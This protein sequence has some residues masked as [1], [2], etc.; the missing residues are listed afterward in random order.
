MTHAVQPSIPAPRPR[1]PKRR[2]ARR[3]F[4]LITLLLL[5]ACLIAPAMLGHVIAY[6]LQSEVATRLHG[7]LELENVYYIFPYGVRIKHASLYTDESSSQPVLD[8]GQIVIKL[9]RFPFGTGLLIFEQAEI[10]NPTVRIIKT[11]AGFQ[12]A[13]LPARQSFMAPPEEKRKLSD[14]FELRHLS[15][16]Q[17]QVIYEDR[18]ND[19]TA[20]APLTWK[21]LTLDFRL[22]PTSTSDYQFIFTA[23]DAALAKMSVNGAINIDTLQLDVPGMNVE[24]NTDPAH[25][26]EQLPPQLQT[27]F[28]KYAVG[29]HLAFTAA[30]KIPLKDPDRATISAQLDLHNGA[31]RLRGPGDILSTAEFTLTA[32]NAPAQTPATLATTLPVALA[33]RTSDILFNLTNLHLAGGDQSLKIETAQARIDR[34]AST[35]A[36]GQIRGVADAGP[37][38]G[39]LRLT[40]VQ[41][42]IPFTAAGF[43]A[44]GDSRDFVIRVALDKANGLLFPRR[45]PVTEVAGKLQITHDILKVSE[46]TGTICGGAAAL[47]GQVSWNNFTTKGVS[48][49]ADG[50]LLDAQMS[51]I[52]QVFIRNEKTRE[53]FTGA[54]DLRAAFSGTFPRRPATQ[55]SL[56]SAF[57]PA[58]APLATT[59]LAIS[60]GQLPTATDTLT[61]AGDFDIRRGSFYQ[62]PVLKTVLGKMKEGDAATVGEAAASFTIAHRIIHFNEAAANSP[63]LGIAGDGDID[64]DGDVDMNFVVTPLADWR[65]K[66]QDTGVPVIKDVVALVAGAA[67]VVLNTAQKVVIYQYRVIGRL[68]A[69]KSETVPFPALTDAMKQ[70][71]QKMAGDRQENSLSAEMRARRSKPATRA[72]P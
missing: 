67:Q 32:A 64:F 5:G 30:A 44:L 72:N 13:P 18:E 57:K 31:C 1:R 65:Q 25:P 53:K 45:M 51:Q 49:E 55:P 36:I 33:D 43:G 52:G 34:I 56:A 66:L 70:T 27:T 69:P 62:I 7:R 35:W 20:R 11:P 39:P 14:L 61:A 71:F 16:T 9:A 8:V 29:G 17:G 2:W 19:I 21:N 4:L 38:R 47:R 48:Y 60:T 10:H 26:S 54:G 46:L 41:Y 6:K 37:G 68:P 58:T 22:T 24:L 50:A 23:N 63:A 59:R 12:S 42:H 3:L 28:K 40:N 15:V